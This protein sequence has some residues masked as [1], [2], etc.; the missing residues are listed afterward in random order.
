LSRRTAYGRKIKKNSP[1]FGFISVLQKSFWDIRIPR[2]IT[3]AVVILPGTIRLY[4]YATEGKS[5]WL[6]WGKNR[7]AIYSSVKG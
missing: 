2:C 6:V 3:K 7:A 1:V 5:F 4:Q